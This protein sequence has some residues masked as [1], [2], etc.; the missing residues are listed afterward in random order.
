MARPGQRRTNQTRR[1]T[2]P[3]TGLPLAPFAGDFDRV[4][5]AGDEF[6]GD[7]DDLAG[8][9]PDLAGDL[10]GPAGDLTGAGA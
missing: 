4:E 5:L 2:P 1:I 6:A 9:L 3:R 8:D 7:L 10:T